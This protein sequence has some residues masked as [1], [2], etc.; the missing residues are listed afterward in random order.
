MLARNRRLGFT[1]VE[2]LVVISIMGILIAL[3]LPAVVEDVDAGVGR[4]RE[5]EPWFTAEGPDFRGLVDA[6][7]PCVDVV[8]AR[9]LDVGAAAGEE[10]EGEDGDQL[11]H[12]GLLDGVAPP[13][14]AAS[15]SGSAITQGGTV[16]AGPP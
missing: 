5:H 11:L 13:R 12:V 8:L 2:A 3:V 7:Q 16:G 4:R 10:C 9:A 1:L 14:G 15:N 6:G